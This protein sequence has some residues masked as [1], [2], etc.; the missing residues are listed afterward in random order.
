MGHVVITVLGM[1]AQMER[2]FIKERQREGIQQAKAKGVYSGGKRRLDHAKV[3]ELARSGTSVAGIAR[4]LGC[5]RMQV[6]RILETR[7]KCGHSQRLLY[8]HAHVQVALPLP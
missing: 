5:S 1:V 4:H 8:A 7:Y 3:R 2:R 6:Y